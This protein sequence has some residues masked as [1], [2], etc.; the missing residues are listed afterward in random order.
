M[1]DKKIVQLLGFAEGIIAF[2][3]IM[4]HRL[5]GI[6][7]LAYSLTSLVATFGDNLGYIDLRAWT[8]ME[9]Q[10]LTAQ[11]FWVGCGW[12]FLAKK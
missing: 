5:G 7:L 2:F 6:F 9:Q 10:A 8:L 12:L 11:I 4:N 3:I 1:D